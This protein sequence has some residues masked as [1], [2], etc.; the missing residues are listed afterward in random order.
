[1]QD[2]DGL[3]PIHAISTGLLTSKTQQ[4]GHDACKCM[5]ILLL[6]YP[7]SIYGIDFS[8]TT[9]LHLLVQ[10]IF[11]SHETNS[12][13]SSSWVQEMKE[14][15]L[16][17]FTMLIHH[18]QVNDD[19][20]VLLMEDESGWSCLHYMYE[21]IH[22]TFKNNN[23]SDNKNDDDFKNDKD[24]DIK[25]IKEEEEEIEE[26]T[27]RKP[28]INLLEKSISKLKLKSIQNDIYSMIKPKKAKSKYLLQRGAYHR[29][30]IEDRNNV[31]QGEQTLENIAKK[32]LRAN[33]ENNSSPTHKIV[34]LCGAGISTSSGIPDYRSKTGIYN[35]KDGKDAFSNFHSNPKQFWE[36]ARKTFGPIFQDEEGETESGSGGRGSGRI[37]PTPCH[38]F[39]SELYKK[40]MLQRVYTQNVDG[41]EVRA[42]IPQEKVIQCHG[43]INTVICSQCSQFKPTSSTPFFNPPTSTQSEDDVEV[44]EALQCPHCGSPLRPD[45]TFFGEPLSSSFFMN[46]DYDF[47]HC[48]MLIVMGTTLQVY[49]FAGLLN[50][51]SLLIPRL[52][53][54]KELTGPFRSLNDGNH[55]FRDVAYLGTCDEGV[56][57]LA[58]LLGWNERDWLSSL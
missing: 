46:Q 43:T 44:E 13:L 6:K 1:L 47:N 57:E 19:D 49:P 34:V 8:D 22:L 7:N 31:L 58:H 29:I 14:P 23:K 50:K 36:F 21:F 54:N 3:L 18:N 30:P 20:N 51:T 35:T 5:E 52:L 4:E 56:K 17:M 41:L 32:I 28:L 10:G 39:L 25:D 40:N 15:I 48:T 2:D 12:S 16:R 24:D 11:N 38:Y 33:N 37:K 26:I 27:I 53:I 9:V 45:V 55:K 42:G